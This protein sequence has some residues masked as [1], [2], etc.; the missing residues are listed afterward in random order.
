MTVEE[1]IEKQNK[2]EKYLESDLRKLEYLYAKSN[3]SSK[4][5]KIVSLIDSNSF[6]K[7]SRGRNEICFV[8]PNLLKYFAMKKPRCSKAVAITS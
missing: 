4:I 2:I 1:L 8:P 3:T 7:N 6:L 5:D